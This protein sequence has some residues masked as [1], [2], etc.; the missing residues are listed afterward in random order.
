MKSNTDGQTR[1]TTVGSGVPTRQT[2]KTTTIHILDNMYV[3]YIYILY[4]KID[5]IIYTQQ[6]PL[7]R[8]SLVTI[9]FAILQRPPP[10]STIDRRRC[11]PYPL[12]IRYFG[13]ITL[14]SY[15][16]VADVLSN[17]YYILPH[18]PARYGPRREFLVMHK[19]VYP[20]I[21]FLKDPFRWRLL[22][23]KRQQHQLQRKGYCTTV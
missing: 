2:V 10:V 6:S 19:W 11:M 9:C 5:F 22:G 8:P 14:L 15:W 12:Q 21:S 3:Q 13:N 7:T 1:I 4:I 17:D 18:G 16:V 20:P 23:L